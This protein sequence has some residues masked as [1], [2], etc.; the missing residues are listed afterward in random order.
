V[1]PH[2]PL[3]YI[4][5]VNWNGWRDTDACLASL[6]ALDY[7]NARVVV[8]DN[9]STDGS[10]TELRRRHPELTLL[11][12]GANLGFAGGNN[13]GL[14]Y[15][16]ERGAEYVWLLN[17]DTL[18]EPD[19]LTHLVA[20]AQRGAAGLPVGLCGSTLVYEGQR[21][22]VQALGG[23]RY[24]RWWG[25]VAA[26]GQHQPREQ[27]I[28]AAAVERQLDYLIGASML[29]SRSFVETVGPMQEDYFL[30]FEEL[31][32]AVRARGR[33]ALAY[34]PESVVY[35]KEGASIGG[36]DRARAAKSYTADRYALTNRVRFTRRFYP[37]ALPTVYLGLGVAL[38]NRVRRRQWD[39][40]GL[41]A[42]VMLRGGA[43]G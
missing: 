37:Y 25:T 9:A 23:A 14:R 36:S 12:S 16:L 39:R 22:T 41:V 4:V 21:D 1:T 10:V 26:I 28:D 29:V 34:A 15:A 2:A 18:V 33:F 7:P 19:A 43:T 31:D 30:Y 20:R 8:V 40:V 38:F 5:I 11:S 32:W 24:N 13:V 6:A 35:H 42:R 3:V 17:N 27:P